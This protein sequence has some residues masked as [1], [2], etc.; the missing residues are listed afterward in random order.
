MVDM[1]ITPSAKSKK[2]QF[3]LTFSGYEKTA[4]ISKNVGI[5]AAARRRSTPRRRSEQESV[6]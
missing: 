6:E 1:L 3:T 5:A 2:L 4:I